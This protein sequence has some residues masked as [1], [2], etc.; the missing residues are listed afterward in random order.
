MFPAP[1]AL[2]SR[3]KHIRRTVYLDACRE[4]R[5]TLANNSPFGSLRPSLKKD[6]LTKNEDV[7]YWFGRYLGVGEMVLDYSVTA[8]RSSGWFEERR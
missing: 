2:Q 5:D 3:I 6:A 7:N 8:A 1:F 4:I